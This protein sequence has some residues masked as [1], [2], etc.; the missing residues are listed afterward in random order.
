MPLGMGGRRFGCAHAAGRIDDRSGAG[1][2]S[3]ELPEAHRVLGGGPD[4]DDRG[5]PVGRQ[6]PALDGVCLR[7]A[8]R[9]AAGIAH[10]LGRSFTL[11]LTASAPIGHSRMDIV[12][13]RSEAFGP[14]GAHKVGRG[15]RADEMYS[16]TGYNQRVCTGPVRSCRGERCGRCQDSSSADIAGRGLRPAGNIACGAARCCPLADARTVPSV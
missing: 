10:R 2:E 3:R 9:H 13:V 6:Q 15:H 11:W 5:S 14:H 12:A 7:S 8:A 4:R 16:G 1:G